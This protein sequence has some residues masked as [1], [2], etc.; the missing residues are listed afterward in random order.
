MPCPAVSV[1]FGA[2][3]IA[4]L[5]YLMHAGYP[6]K[7][8]SRNLAGLGYDQ[9]S[10]KHKHPEKVYAENQMQDSHES[11]ERPGSTGITEIPGIFR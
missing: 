1:L 5:E 7:E 10:L 3:L 4:E 8:L 9:D 11:G 6:E 2:R